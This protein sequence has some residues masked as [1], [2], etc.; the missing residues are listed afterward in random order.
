M[1]EDEEKQLIEDIES[2]KDKY[3]KLTND[4]ITIK[5]ELDKILRGARIK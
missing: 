3:C 4:I 5:N 2:L 1:N